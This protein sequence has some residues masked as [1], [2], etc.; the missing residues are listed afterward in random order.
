[1][2][3]YRYCPICSE[4]LA[5]R[6]D[7]ERTRPVC[8]NCGFVHYLN[9]SPAAGVLV[10]KEGSVLLV[11]R[12]YQPYR[13]MWVM[14]SGYIEYEED[15]EDTA[16]RELREETGLLAEL[17][18]IH[19]VVSVSDDPRG[20]TVMVLY[21]GHITGGEL[22]AG[23]DAE[24]VRFFPLDDLPPVAFQAQRTILGRLSRRYRK[25]RD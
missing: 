10:M 13:G 17:D 7:G 15:V 19:T 12:R 5:E 24:D 23:D 2:K 25:G 16:L 8:P 22:K 21:E 14:P 1:M 6:D 20:N 9:P 3:K 4:E 11:R 18:G